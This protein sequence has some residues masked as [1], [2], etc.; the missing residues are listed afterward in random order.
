MAAL[1]F[2]ILFSNRQ[3]SLRAVQRLGLIPFLVGCGFQLLSYNASGYS[4]VKEWYWAG[5]MLFTLFLAALLVDLILPRQLKGARAEKLLLAGALVVSLVWFNSLA[6]F[7]VKTM[8]PGDTRAGEPYVDALVVL[9]AHTEPGTMIGVTGGGN[10]GYFIQDRTI[11]NMDGLINSAEYY[12]SLRSGNAA[13]Y[14]YESGVDYVFA[15]PSILTQLAPFKYQFKGRLIKTGVV[16]GNKELMK[17]R[18]PRK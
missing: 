12:Q 5:Q 11:V 17:I 9:E 7:V 15:N 16:F 6:Q 2:V 13:D 14:L 10:L 18:P 4:A 3:R 1:V 8:P